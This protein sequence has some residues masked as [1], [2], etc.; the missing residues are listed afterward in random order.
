M[1]TNIAWDEA[2]RAL[3]ERHLRGGSSDALEFR[4]LH[5]LFGAALR[6]GRTLIS[7]DAAND[8]RRGGLPSGHPSLNVFMDVPLFHGGEMVGRV[9]LANRVGGYEQALVDRLQPLF[10]SVAYG[11]VFRCCSVWT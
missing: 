8:P 7:N 6:E 1:L 10:T 4:N 2:T 5:S 9:G 3:Y 11:A